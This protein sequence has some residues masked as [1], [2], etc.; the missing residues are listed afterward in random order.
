[1]EG[2]GGQDR[3]AR[4]WKSEVKDG[5]QGWRE[6]G[7]EKAPHS[8]QDWVG[9]VEVTDTGLGLLGVAEQRA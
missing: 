9:D 8:M 3:W 7:I 1:M 2:E 6:E 4:R 5:P